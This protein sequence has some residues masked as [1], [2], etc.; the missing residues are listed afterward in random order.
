MYAVSPYIFPVCTLELSGIS[1][2]L[3][4]LKLVERVIFGALIF[5]ESHPD[6]ALTVFMFLNF[7][8]W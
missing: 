7:M 4:A 6:E 1:V 2:Y 5:V 8:T 3:E